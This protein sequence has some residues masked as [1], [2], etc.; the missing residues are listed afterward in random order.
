MYERKTE[1]LVMKNV[2]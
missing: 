1:V 2:R